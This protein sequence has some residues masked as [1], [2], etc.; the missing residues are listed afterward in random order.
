MYKVFTLLAGKKVSLHSFMSTGRRSKTP[1]LETKERLLLIAI[2]VAR[3]SELVPC[4]KSQILQSQTK[5]CKSYLH[6]WYRRGNLRLESGSFI[7]GN[8]QT[9]FSQ[10]EIVS[11]Y[12]IG[13]QTCL[14]LRG[15][16]HPLNLFTIQMSLKR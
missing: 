16:S 2:A 3:I 4:S 12:H 7:R 15:K 14:M 9:D 5:R 6:V 8:M 1:E 11:L 13:Q 10:R